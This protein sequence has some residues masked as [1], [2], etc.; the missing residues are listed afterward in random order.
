M[1]V[2]AGVQAV[3]TGRNKPRG[4]RT[5]LTPQ[6]RTAL[7]ARCRSK[8]PSLHEGSNGGILALQDESVTLRKH[9]G[10]LCGRYGFQVVHQFEISAVPWKANVWPI[11]L[12]AGKDGMWCK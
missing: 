3:S 4:R 6:R 7:S 10:G 9:F 11:W 12:E 1:R 5:R 2:G 8:R